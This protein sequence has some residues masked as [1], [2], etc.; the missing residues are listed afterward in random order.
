VLELAD[1]IRTW[2]RAGQPVT[3]VRLVETEGFSSREREHVVALTPGHSAVGSLLAGALDAQLASVIDPGATQRSLIDLSVS[4]AVAGA[5]GLSCGGIARLLVHPSTDIDEAG[6]D[7]LVSGEPVCLI[8]PLEPVVGDTEVFTA[9]TIAA[10][11]RRYGPGVRR[12]FNRGATQTGLLPSPRRVVTALWPV[13][14]LVVVGAGLIAE[15]L[16]SI[17]QLLRWSARIVDGGDA[18]AATGALNHADAVIVLSH[19]RAVDGPALESALSGGA[20]YVGALG[21]ARTQAE[22]ARWLAERGVSA[23][24]IASVH[25]PAGLDLGAN[26]PAE[27]AVSVVAE[28]L[29]VRSDTSGESLRGRLGPIRP[30]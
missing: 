5:A 18:S 19:D 26:T 28:I 7:A 20:G 8:T 12:S 16:Q 13:P 23:A 14:S 15:A 6:W 2:Q 21:S 9:E 17:A 25:G 11:E 30:S 27:I 10:A 29:A 24:K 4:D 22:R 3:I 1:Q